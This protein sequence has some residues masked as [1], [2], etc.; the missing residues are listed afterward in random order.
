MFLVQLSSGSIVSRFGTSLLSVSIDREKAGCF[1][2]LVWFAMLFFRLNV[3]FEDDN[4][5]LAGCRTPDTRA[6]AL[7]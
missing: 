5:L 6:R 7:S 2:A 4:N 1:E 3:F